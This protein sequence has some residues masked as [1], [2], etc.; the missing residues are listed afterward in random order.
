[1]RINV[2]KLMKLEEGEALEQLTES[3]SLYCRAYDNSSEQTD[4]NAHILHLLAMPYS[5]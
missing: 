1:M 5:C 2:E 4:L 3:L